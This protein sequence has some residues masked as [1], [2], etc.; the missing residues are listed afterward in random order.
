MCLASQGS[1][2]GLTGKLHLPKVA[3]AEYNLVCCFLFLC[4]RPAVSELHKQRLV[5]ARQAQAEAS[6]NGQ[7]LGK[8]SAEVPGSA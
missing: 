5:A 2:S 8:A 3:D 6:L 1:K 4:R 7:A